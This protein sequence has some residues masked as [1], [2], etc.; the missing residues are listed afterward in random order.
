MTVTPVGGHEDRKVN[1]RVLAATSRELR[2]MVQAGTFREDLYYRLNVIPVQLP[3]LRERP[4][5]SR[6]LVAQFVKAIA[7]AE[8]APPRR[9]SPGVI[10]RLRAFRW[11]GNVR[12]PRTDLAQMMVLAAGEFL[13]ERELPDPRAESAPSTPS[14]SETP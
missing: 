4:A 3:P 7:N 10:R 13:A 2:S 11:P 1:V 14:A 5:D 8:G 9:V 12:E 6:I